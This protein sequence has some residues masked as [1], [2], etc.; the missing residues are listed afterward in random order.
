MIEFECQHYELLFTLKG[1]R[2]CIL[3]SVHSSFDLDWDGESF[4]RVVVTRVNDV[5][6][7]EQE[8]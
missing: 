4:E 5:R 6:M 8:S 3:S 1:F 7:C 2:Y